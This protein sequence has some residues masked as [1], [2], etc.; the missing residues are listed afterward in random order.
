MAQSKFLLRDV[1][2]IVDCEHKT[3]PWVDSSGYL[4]ARTSDVRDG[5]LLVDG[6]RHTTKEAFTQWT[7][8]AVPEE[9]DVLFTREAPAGECCLVPAGMNI[10]PGQ[11][12]VLLRP[13]RQRVDSRF[14]S[15]QLR[16]PSC[17]Q[18]LQLLSVKSTVSRINITDL[19]NLPLWLPSLAEQQRIAAILSVWTKAIN[20]TSQLLA[21]RQVQK[22]NMIERS[23]GNSRWPVAQVSDHFW[24]QEGPGIL[25]KQFTRSGV[26]LLNG[27]NIR[28]N[29]LA[30][31]NT[32]KWISADAAEQTYR[33]FLVEE[34]DLLIACSG[35]MIDRF[36]EKIAFAEKR[37]LPLCMNTSTMRFRATGALD[38]RFFSYFLQSSCFKEQIRRLATGSAQLNFG[39]T[40]LAKC[41][42]AIPPQ[43]EQ[44]KIVTLL[45]TADREIT[46]LQEKREQLV[47]EQI[48]L[49]ERLTTGASSAV[50][51]PLTDFRQ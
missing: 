35:I 21:L 7:R 2:Q 13:D 20:L 19:R 9:G 32:D 47:M 6:L 39:P 5:Q 16:S 48:A 33:H 17:Q 4:V 36:D 51:P 50:S 38:I 31:D 14:L 42:V 37:H 24:F 26:K 12:M 10:C 18:Q 29:R 8:K 30:P 23:M 40:H 46:R 22:K 45:S 41:V 3:P 15:F 43:G 49:I 27:T 44:R 34:G 25:R 28:N 1:C 11:R